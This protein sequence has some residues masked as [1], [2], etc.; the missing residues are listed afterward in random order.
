MDKPPNAILGTQIRLTLKPP[1]AMTPTGAAEGEAVPLFYRI[2]I[3]RMQIGHGLDVVLTI[4]PRDNPGLACAYGQ[5]D[6]LVEEV[7]RRWR[8]PDRLVDV[9]IERMRLALE[10]ETGR[11]CRL[12]RPS[13]PR[14]ATVE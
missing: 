4:H 2:R 7:A 6:I 10:R 3:E 13:P 9:T 14:A 8:S 11:P 5:R 1:I 12:L